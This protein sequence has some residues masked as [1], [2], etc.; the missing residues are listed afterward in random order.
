MS[1]PLLSEESMNYLT[2]NNLIQGR[3]VLSVSSY[4]TDPNSSESSIEV[5]DRLYSYETL[6][7]CDFNPCTASAI[8]HAYQRAVREY[9]EDYIDFE[10]YMKLAIYAVKA[11]DDADADAYLEEED[12]DD[13]TT[14]LRQLGA[15]QHLI[16][17]LMDPHWKE[18]RLLGTAKSWMWFIVS[19]RYE[20]LQLLDVSIKERRVRKEASA[21][22]AKQGMAVLSPPITEKKTAKPPI[23]PHQTFYKGGL[24]APLQT[25]QGPGKSLFPRLLLSKPPGDFHAQIGGLH[26]SKHRQVAWEHARMSASILDGRNVLE[27][28]ILSI[29]IPISLLANSYSVEENEWR[30]FVF[31]NRRSDFQTLARMGY[32]KEYD[33]LQGPVCGQATD[34]VRRLS[35]SEGLTLMTFGGETAHQ[36][37]TGKPSMFLALQER[38][39]PSITV[40]QNFPASPPPKK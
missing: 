26:L 31:A 34:I 28:G 8:F 3:T 1:F 24:L 17:R 16:D 4:S 38:A 25:A 9:G 33:W 29:N 18:T 10:K 39:Q 22:K 32:I 35:S 27:T 12:D 5:P 36:I 21:V 11:D 19:S 15:N 40:E 13:W 14:A 7:I 6:I 30:A 2:A 23:E 37:W 20:W